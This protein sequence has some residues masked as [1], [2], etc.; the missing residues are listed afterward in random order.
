MA[1]GSK[2]DGFIQKPIYTWG[3]LAKAERLGRSNK[4]TLPHIG[5]ILGSPKPVLM[6]KS[7]I[8][9]V[10]SPLMIA[11]LPLKTQWFL[12]QTGQSR[13]PAPAD[14]VAWL[15]LSQLCGWFQPSWGSLLQT[16][17]AFTVISCIVMLCN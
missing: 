6:V 15:V 17:R 4:A 13:S 7:P 16:V 10:E 12:P 2:L 3:P 11:T 5:M 9:T 1:F 8:L 14:L